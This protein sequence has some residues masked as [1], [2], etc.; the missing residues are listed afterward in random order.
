MKRD[1]FLSEQKIEYNDTSSHIYEK[2]PIYLKR[3][4]NILKE[5]Y[6]YLSRRYN[7]TPYLHTHMEKD[8]HI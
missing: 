4:L 6:F 5:T 7:M 2:R 1:L 3:D 8:L